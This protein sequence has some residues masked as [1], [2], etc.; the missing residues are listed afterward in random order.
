MP[1]LTFRPAR[2]TDGRRGVPRD[3]AFLVLCCA[4]AFTLAAQDS[5]DVPPP[6]PAAA[7]PSPR[8][9]ATEAAESTAEGSEAS[10]GGAASAEETEPDLVA[11]TMA[12]DI[13]TADYYELVA[14]A[15]SLGL[16]DAGTAPE[17][18]NRL[19]AH[20]KVKAPAESAAGGKRIRIESANR[21]EYVKM[22]DEDEK[23]IRL[24]GR[25][26]LS[27][28][29]DSSGETHRIEA[30]RIVYNQTTGSLTASGRI[31]YSLKKGETTQF[32]YGEK[33]AINLDTW[34]GVFLE[35]L[36]KRG[37]TGSQDAVYM[38]AN[39]IVKGDD[40][41]LVFDDATITTCAEEDPHYSIR[42]S[43]VWILGPNEWAIANAVLS[44]GEVPALYLPFFYYP[45]QEIV[46][47]PVF[48]YRDREGRFVQT[49]TY[50][51]GEKPAKDDSISVFKLVSS[52]TDNAKELKG[53]FLRQTEEKKKASISD[54][55]KIIADVY[56][57]LGGS[58]GVKGRQETVGPLKGLEYSAG[59]G[60]SRSV[61][62]TPELIYTP[63]VL[64]SDYASVWNGSTFFGLDVPFRYSFDLATRISLGKLGIGV[65]LAFLSDPFW[66]VDFSSRTEDMDW[67]KF[68]KPETKETT[69]SERSSFSER[70]DTQFSF[71]VSAFA[72]YL[73]ALELQRFSGSMLWSSK[74]RPVPTD[75]EERTRYY[76]DPERKFFFP[77]QWIV[78][79]LALSARG[80][81]F[82]WPPAAGATAAAASSA[83]SAPRQDVPAGVTAPW[84]TDTSSSA[85]GEAPDEVGDGADKT[86]A[87]AAAGGPD[88]RGFPPPESAPI[89]TIAEARAG[90]ASVGYTLGAQGAYERR[91]LGAAWIV[92]EDVDWR[93]LYDLFTYKFSA[94]V[95]GGLSLF[96]QAL[97]LS[98]AL[99]YTTQ[100]QLRPYRSDDAAYVTPALEASWAQQDGQA[101]SQR[102]GSS[103]KASLSPFLDWWLW[104]KTSLVYSIDARLYSVLFTGMDGDEPVY[105]TKTAEFTKEG[106]AAHSLEAIAAVQPYGFVQS[107]SLSSTLPPLD[108]SYG[109][110]LSLKAPFTSLSAST[111]Y[112]APAGLSFRWDP[113][114]TNAEF[115]VPA[116]PRLTNSFVYD[117]EGSYPV[118]DNATLGYGG[119]SASFAMRRSK[120][121]W[122]DPGTGWQV[123][124]ASPEAFRPTDLSAAY[125]LETAL[126]P[127]WRNRVSVKFSADARFSQSLLRYSEST[128]SF[129]TSIG[130]SV[131]EAFELSFS[132]SSQ[133]PSAWRYFPGLFDLG[134]DVEPVNPVEDIL[135]SLNFFDLEARKAS[136][137][138]LR[139]LSVKIS[140]KLHDWDLSLEFTGKPLLDPAARKYLFDTSVTALVAW[141][142]V[143]EFSTKTIGNS[144]GLTVE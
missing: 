133:N 104:S 134:F 7:N 75:P 19:Y 71:P 90:A 82:S 15:K 70:V 31:S 43:R 42:A 30:D 41:W 48:G 121:Y 108:P 103:F 22:V 29:I 124:A 53:V 28:V 32:Y 93:A 98:T 60:L 92:P 119:F 142:P 12:M 107:F 16:S 95:N 6:A 130:V 74:T 136:F 55:V 13:A 62:T 37:Q 36:M 79:D 77:D 38:E 91:F 27:V 112:Y 78:G 8:D 109:F 73:S 105:E 128:L 2:A 89:L 17:L 49:T 76:V 40:G 86:A 58:V 111:K 100:G 35:G 20:Y 9:G 3:L 127:Y 135:S 51:V 117:L 50:L 54:Y 123:D 101:H 85:D 97:N 66:D 138:K 115:A 52:A 61:F 114:T 18:R 23:I 63:H 143:P 110:K 72:P 57:N 64:E 118:T 68:M 96:G 47:H 116:G 106:I 94:G 83:G 4:C 65:K 44:V 69:A 21:T 113:L 131:F 45:G 144:A 120:A 59:L 67:L 56:G 99:T 129:T 140:R 84:E 87:P 81:L 80:D 34:Q 26:V 39:T 137:F 132:S 125:R 5:G 139:S 102:L 25:V 141:R 11:S 88:A 46:F 122:L 10:D 24:S 14:W 126:P 33:L 1:R